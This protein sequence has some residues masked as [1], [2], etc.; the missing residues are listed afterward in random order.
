MI[1]V[2]LLGLALGQKYPDL[3]EGATKPEAVQSQGTCCVKII[4][5]CCDEK[6]TAVA[7]DHKANSGTA[8][9]VSLP[10]WLFGLALAEILFSIKL[11]DTFKRFALTFAENVYR[12]FL[13]L[14]ACCKPGAAG[15]AASSD[16]N[17][18]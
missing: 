1:A 16:E 17:G 4:D 9:P 6:N 11:Y 5:T 13:A 18:E 14:G 3:Q 12:D 7:A 10:G 15:A 8:R 2:L